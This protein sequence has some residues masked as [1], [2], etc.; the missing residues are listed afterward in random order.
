MFIRLILCVIFLAIAP[1]AYGAQNQ[2]PGVPGE[3]GSVSVSSGGKPAGQNS[4]KAAN[5]T[6]IA[7]R[8]FSRLNNVRDF[9]FARKIVGKAVYY[10][11]KALALDR[12]NEKLT[13]KYIKAVNMRYNL[14]IPTGEKPDIKKKIY[15]D[16]L[17][18]LESIYPSMENSAYIS[19]DMSFILIQ[20][21][22]FYNPFEAI[23]AVNR[24][25]KHA[26]KV[27]KK[28]P[29]FENYDAMAVLGRIHY[30]APNIPFILTWPDKKKSKK[31][32][33]KVHANNPSSRLIK[34]FLADTL[35]ELGGA[36]RER[37]I[38]Y[39]RDAAGTEPRHDINYFRDLKIKK[40][41]GDR[42]RQLGI[43]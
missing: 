13:H 21:L 25:K 24:I 22:E 38:M 18:M 26:E 17:K 42:M 35:Y 16:T 28:N 2:A 6:R 34:F 32:L 12:H 9:K 14:L 7:N 5:Y 23:S 40:E 41:C 33:E 39:Y 4:E 27:C 37:A 36:D 3:E 1:Y 19:Y 10:Y 15:S 11:K 30:L 20:L 29:S 8:I 31:Y 43:K